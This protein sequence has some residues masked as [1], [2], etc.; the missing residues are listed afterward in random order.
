MTMENDRYLLLGGNGFLGKNLAECLASR[1]IGVDVL[2]LPDLDLLKEECIGELCEAFP[3][4]GK[5]VLLASNVGAKLFT[6]SP[7]TAA[8]E[9]KSIF[10]N[11]IKALKLCCQKH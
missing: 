11:T 1:S 5:V 6:V 7:K 4:Y 3:K 2:D 10:D 9:N 8:E